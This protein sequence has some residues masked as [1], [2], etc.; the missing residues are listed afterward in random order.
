MTTVEI[1]PSVPAR[2]VEPEGDVR[3][4]ESLAEALFAASSRFDD[5]GGN[6]RSHVVPLGG[7]DLDARATYVAKTTRLADQHEGMSRTLDRV[8]RH[9]A[10]Y[11]DTLRDLRRE[12]HGLVD[13]KQSL[14]GRRTQLVADVQAAVDP[15]TDAVEA[16]RERAAELRADYRE[17]TRD[18]DALQVRVRAAEDLLVESFRS[19][20]GL[21]DAVS[22]EGGGTHAADRVMDR[23][24]AP[25]PGASPGQ[26][27]DWWEHLT[28]AER[29][30]V[31][32]L[33][34]GRIGSA[35]G[36]PAD[37]R[38][39]ANRVL[40]ADDLATL[41]A[42]EDDGTLTDAERRVLDNA[43]ETRRALERA[44]DVED[45]ITGERP[46]GQLYLYD[47]GAFDGDGRVAVAVGDLDTAHDVAV[48]T[49][50]IKTEMADTSGYTGQMAN[51]YE[52]ARFAGDG[53]S[54]ATMFYLGYDT[55]DS[56]TD[57]ATFGE[58]R[59]A[60]GGRRLAEMV[61]GLRASR[62]DDPAHLT[63][64]GHS[65]GS[66]ATSYAAADHDLDADDVVLIGS[67]GAGPAHDAGDL[68][69]GAD[70]VFVGRDS[71][72]GV[73]FVGD[74]GWIGKGGLGLGRDPSSDD[75][76]ATRFE[77]ENTD[78]AWHPDFD[79]AHSRYLDHD[80][81]SLYNLGRIVDGHGD[82]VNEAAHSY[83]PWYAGAVDPEW[84]RDP[85]SG[86]EGSSQTQGRSVVR[87]AGR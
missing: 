38:D 30:A 53:S 22:G 61:D 54:V 28:D 18:H 60:D 16:L 2:I 70:H 57:P 26:V 50:G 15:G 59:A 33:Y 75:F 77:A 85:T 69:V 39:Q 24:G 68:G 7:F 20:A 3:G 42:K 80:T 55:P 79:E 56:P 64:I 6:A 29:E 78:R 11:A 71:R 83:D 5:V 25:G 52:S 45:P 32:A 8:A 21:D 13:L 14:D 10:A 34:P 27:R 23:P 82:D 67:P 63:A 73:A 46:G 17:L 49:P 48:F 47:P 44:D 36:L 4:A 9:V 1:P 72:D 37:A 12:W 81:E 31:I 40:L 35:D 51:L 41:R 62:P 65:Y 87:S 84:S 43:E 58:A 74:E 19:G 86:V 66:T 76:G